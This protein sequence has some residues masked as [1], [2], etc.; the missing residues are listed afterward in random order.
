MVSQAAAST[1]PPA[2][3]DRWQD[4]DPNR[5]GVLFFISSES[6]FFLSLIT[7]FIVYRPK[8][9]ASDG[10]SLLDVPR[11]GIFTVLLIASSVTIMFASARL[12]RGDRTGGIIWLVA[13]LALGTV[14]L[15][16]QVTEYM[17]LAAR[18]LI[19]S[20]NLFGSTFYTLTGFHSFHVFVGL[21]AIAIVLLV[22]LLRD[23]PARIYRAVEPVSYYWHFVDVVWI[24]V[25]SVIYLWSLV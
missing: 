19:P 18:G 17:G 12:R 24:V 7:A 10:L 22:A 9:P 6:V 13:T 14:F 16:G 23:P 25:F 1:P 3:R 11:T 8:V 20:S 2:T 4:I 5:L 15:Y 21:V